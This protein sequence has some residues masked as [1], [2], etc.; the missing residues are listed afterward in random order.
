[1]NFNGGKT[2]VL[3]RAMGD[4]WRT[5]LASIQVKRFV[6][7]CCGSGAV[8]TYINKIRPDLA[9]V[10]NDLHPAV[11]AL[12]RAVSCEGWVPPSTL[13][14]VEYLALKA[15]AQAGEISP[16]VGFAGFGA[17][18]SGQYFKGFAKPHA[19]QQ[20]KAAASARALLADAPHLA[21]ADFYNLD[22][23]ALPEAVGVRE[24]D[25][26]YIDPPYA[27]TM[28]FRGVPKF[29]HARFWAWAAALAQH[30]PVLVSEFTAPT[31]W[32]S[33][34][35]FARKLET[36]N[37][38]GGVSERLDQVFTLSAPEWDSWLEREAV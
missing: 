37:T 14:E 23:A 1:M 33:M 29:D 3:R 4:F 36:R 13:S 17:S 10:C 6:D 7:V 25:V 28:G 18:F 15:R 26:W 2:F 21:R 8:S 16:L 20:D 5:Y 24:G 12:L 11:I 34:W 22:Y 30:V 19:K 35:V 38:Q 9:L 32:R 27:G 31:E